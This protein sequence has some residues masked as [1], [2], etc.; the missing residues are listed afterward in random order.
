MPFHPTLDNE[1]KVLDSVVALLQSS[2][3][4]LGPTFLSAA[5]RVAA[6]ILPLLP[7]A[8]SSTKS[9]VREVLF[10]LLTQTCHS[11]ISNLAQSGESFS[12]LIAL[13]ALGRKVPFQQDVESS[14]L[15]QAIFD[16]LSR[17]E[18]EPL[19][20]LVRSSLDVLIPQATVRFACLASLLDAPA[21]L[22]TAKQQLLLSVL[23]GIQRSKAV[24]AWIHAHLS[25]GSSEQTPL[26]VRFVGLLMQFIAE[27]SD[28]NP[29][30]PHY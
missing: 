16:C 19:N 8:T 17:H 28:R 9:R 21:P 1:A 6:L 11:H 27:N 4:T 10:P 20:T 3:G 29:C 30:L 14:S 15:V 23:Y 7:L 25:E 12:A 2:G 13:V 18:S 5:H 24:R 22:S 26:I